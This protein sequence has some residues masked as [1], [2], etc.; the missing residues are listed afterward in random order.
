MNI[1]IKRG[2]V[3]QSLE[4]AQKLI[5]QHHMELKDGTPSRTLIIL[6]PGNPSN[7]PKRPQN[8]LKYP[9]KHAVTLSL[10]FSLQEEAWLTNYLAGPV[11][12]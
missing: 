7:L 9:C 8:K 2:E 1:E 11:G 5:G 3:N 4:P 6:T 12:F 10:T